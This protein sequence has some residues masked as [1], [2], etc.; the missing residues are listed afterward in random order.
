M[1]AAH[2]AADNVAVPNNPNPPGKSSRPF[3]LA[4]KRPKKS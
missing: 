3:L 4:T 1:M 2:S